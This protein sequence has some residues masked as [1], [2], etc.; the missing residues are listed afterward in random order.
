MLVEDQSEVMEF[1]SQ[2]AAYGSKAPRVDRIDTHISAIFLVD[3]RAYKLKRAVRLPYLDFSTADRRREACQAEVRINRRTAPDIYRGVTAVVRDTDDGLRLV[4]DSELTDETAGAV[5]DWLVSMLRFD[6]ETLFDRLAAAGKLDRFAIEDVADAI[7][8]FHQ[9]AEV[10]PDSGGAAMIASVID[11]NAGCFTDPAADF[12][13]KDRVEL[14]TGRSR[15][16][17]EEVSGTLEERRRNGRVRHCHG[18]LHLSNIFLHDGQAT[19]F[20]AIEF[21]AEFSDIDVLYDL[22]FLVMDLDHRDLRRLA[23]ILLNRYLD[24][25]GDAAGLGAMPLFL[26]VR[27]AIR[28]HVT[29][30]SATQQGQAEA[31]E[32]ER[33]EARIYLD[34]ALRYLEPSPPRLVAVGGLSGTGKSR[35]ARDMAPYFNSAAGARVVRTDSTRKRL[36]GV[37][38]DT[39]LGSGGYSPELSRRTYEAV[40]EECRA[41]IAAGCSVI[42]DAVFAAADERQAIERIAADLGVPFAG[43]WLEAPAEVMQERVTRRQRNVSDATPWVINLQ[44]QY[45]LGEI[46]WA[47]IDTTASRE[48]TL[49]RA[50]AAAGVR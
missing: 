16:A 18:D 15:R 37:S 36:A 14:V 25:T 34:R 17:L 27:A 47:R 31:A 19:L 48:A 44:L 30:L 41:V 50:L 2:P 29:A 13:P 23:S 42:A 6:E 12:L 20:D 28:S 46:T 43:L 26:S 24:A 35:L 21:R 32:A 8:R 22:A 10:R 39:R 7:A 40:F 1:L 11:S 9:A 38:L 3:D 5:V 49:D 33:G 45:E 4:P